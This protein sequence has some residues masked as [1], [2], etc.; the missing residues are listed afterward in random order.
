MR[1]TVFENMPFSNPGSL[2]PAQYAN[3]MAFLLA[4]NCLPS[5]AKPFPTANSPSLATIKFAALHAAKPT[6]AKLATCPIK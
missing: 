3:V 6:N 5:S 1:T 4:S 2:K